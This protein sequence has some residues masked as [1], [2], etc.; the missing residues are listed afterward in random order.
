MFV[1]FN[2]LT[3]I[4]TPLKKGVIKKFEKIV[5]K[6]NFVLNEDTKIFENNFSKFT[7]QKYAVSCANGTDA[8][9]L[10]LRGL[11]IGVGDEV[12]VPVI[13]YRYIICRRKC[14]TKP[15]FVDNDEYY[16]INLKKIKS[17]ITKKTKAIIE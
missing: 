16:L 10:L 7:K 17:K 11:G 1:P 2:D 12:I 4:H 5:D 9:E 8:I 13:L 15:I 14:G 6:N 3:R